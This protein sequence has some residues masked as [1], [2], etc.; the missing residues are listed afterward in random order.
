MREKPEAFAIAQRFHVGAALI[1]FLGI[2]RYRARDRIVQTG[3]E[4]S[5]VIRGDLYV[6]LHGQVGNRLADVAVIV[7]HLRNGEPLQQKIVAVL[8]GA[9]AD[10][11]VRDGAAFTQRLDE[12]PQKQRHA[13]VDLRFGRDGN[14]PRCDLHA[15]P[16]NELVAVRRH[17]LIERRRHHRAPVSARTRSGRA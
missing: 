12:L 3:I 5:K 6:A 2:L 16:P 13:V 4:R 15:A 7:D 9:A 8:H 1:A 11:G 10:R 14:R 17:E